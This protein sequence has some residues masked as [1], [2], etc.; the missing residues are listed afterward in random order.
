MGDHWNDWWYEQQR[1]AEAQ[2]RVEQEQERQRWAKNEEQRREQEYWNQFE[3]NVRPEQRTGVIRPRRSRGPGPIIGASLGGCLVLLIALVVLY[4]IF[5]HLSSFITTPATVNSSI[6]VDYGASGYRY[7]VVPTGEGQ[8]FEAQNY[9]EAAFQDGTAAFG[10]AANGCTLDP[11]IETRWPPNT[12]ILVRRLI[13]VPNGTGQVTIDV[14]IDNDVL[15]YWNGSL[16]GQATHE[17]CAIRDTLHVTILQSQIH[18][19]EPNLLAVRG[20]DRGGSTYLD[21]QIQSQ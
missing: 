15:M 7:E 3:R 2:R 21:M 19:G 10:F 18:K 6:L 11:T 1:A 13:T 8:G 16:V 12:D 17:E 14:A 5:V 20:I 9:S 4:Q